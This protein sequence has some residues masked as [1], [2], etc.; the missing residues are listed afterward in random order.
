MPLWKRKR[1]S[2]KQA[3]PSPTGQLL[4]EGW[5]GLRWGASLSEFKA[6]FPQATEAAE[7]SWGTDLAHS[8]YAASR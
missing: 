5:N 8:R 7:R 4:A 2:G 1:G 3:T 6:R